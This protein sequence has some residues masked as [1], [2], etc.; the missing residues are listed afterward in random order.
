MSYQV[1]KNLGALLDQYRDDTPIDLRALADQV[2]GL[3]E[4]NMETVR[5][6]LNR[7]TGAMPPGT[8]CRHLFDGIVHDSVVRDVLTVGHLAKLLSRLDVLT[9][10]SNPMV[11]GLSNSIFD[12]QSQLERAEF[13][14]AGNILPIDAEILANDAVKEMLGREKRKMSKRGHPFA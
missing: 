6:L 2:A 12:E 7:A 10:A 11:V 1:S 4:K 3:F 14:A 9:K 8:V 5:S 13:F